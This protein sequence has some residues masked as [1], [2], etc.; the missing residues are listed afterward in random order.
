MSSELIVD[1]IWKQLTRAAKATRA[2]SLAAVAYF[3][4]GASKLLPLCRNSRLIVDASELAVKSGQTCPAELSRLQKTGVR[5]FS[6]PNLHAK[7][8]VFGRRLFIGSTNASNRSANT[9]IEAIVTTTDSD[10]VRAARKF[11][12]DLCVHELG[13]DA[14]HE[15]QSVY[16][17]PRI[18][19]AR[20]PRR[21]SSNTR[22]RIALPRIRIAQL[23]EG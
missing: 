22:N 8:F 11:V 1:D 7:L 3:G 13:P 9:L 18:L 23:T 14:L 2:P 12:K 15:L 16:R 19:G 5:I 17:P 10:A 21:K 20:A 4:K 6:V